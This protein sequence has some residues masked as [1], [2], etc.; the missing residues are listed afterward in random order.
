MSEMSES[1]APPTRVRRCHGSCGLPLPPATGAAYTVIGPD[2]TLRE[3]CDG[4]C[5]GTYYLGASRAEDVRA[6]LALAGLVRGLEAAARAGPV[7]VVLT[8]LIGQP[9]ACELSADGGPDGEPGRAR[10]TGEGAGQTIAEAIT[11][12]LAAVRT[13]RP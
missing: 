13:E 11:R 10:V 8:H 7:D 5:L 1:T 6:R 12:A 4:D 3:F 9:W 2:G